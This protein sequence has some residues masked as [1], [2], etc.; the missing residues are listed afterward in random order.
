MRKLRFKSQDSEEVDWQI[1]KEIA[2]Q[3]PLDVS[4][5]SVMELVALISTRLLLFNKNSFK[6]L[7]MLFLKS[8]RKFKMSKMEDKLPSLRVNQPWEGLILEVLE[9]HLKM[10]DLNFP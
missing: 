4:H 7:R 9:D 10:M 8:N 5:Q 3:I 1:S 2:I 6:R